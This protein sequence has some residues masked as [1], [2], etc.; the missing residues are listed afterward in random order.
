MEKHCSCHRLGRHCSCHRLPQEATGYAP[1][2][3]TTPIK[4][5][6]APIDVTR[7]KPF[8]NTRSDAWG[9]LLCGRVGMLSPREFTS[10]T[11]PVTTNHRVLASPLPP[12]TPRTSRPAPSPSVVREMQSTTEILNTRR[13]YT[14]PPP[15]TAR[16]TTHT[17]GY[18][19]T[20]HTPI[21]TA[22]PITHPHLRHFRIQTLRSMGLRRESNGLK[23]EV[24]PYKPLSRACCGRID[25]TEQDRLWHLR[26]FA[27]RTNRGD[28]HLENEQEES[29]RL[30]AEQQACRQRA[31]GVQMI[32]KTGGAG[33]ARRGSTQDA[34]NCRCAPFT[35][36]LMTPQ[37]RRRKMECQLQFRAHTRARVA[38]RA[39]ERM[40]RTPRIANA[41]T[42]R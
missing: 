5:P 23:S 21:T 26:L 35:E 1:I 11:R 19:D 39:E 9:A 29:I 20:R 22:A 30:V 24:L 31:K 17:G 41:Q 28:W 6:S 42:A 32:I 7:C 18:V 16:S 15:A 38:G 25:S 36:K 10:C 3:A 34:L 14:H 27:E 12:T 37:Q 8:S 4:T 13:Q 33:N 40:L 2:I